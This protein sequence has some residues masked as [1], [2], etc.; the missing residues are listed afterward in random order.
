MRGFLVGHGQG[1]LIQ[2]VGVMDNDTLIGCV[3]LAAAL[4]CVTYLVLRS[5]R[6]IEWIA[7]HNVRSVREILKRMHGDVD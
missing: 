5:R 1:H 7:K 3:V 2:M 4:G 6:T